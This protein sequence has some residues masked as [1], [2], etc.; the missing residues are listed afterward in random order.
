MADRVV[1]HF[2]VYFGLARVHDHFGLRE[3]VLRANWRQLS[4][5]LALPETPPAP[6]ADL[7]QVDRGALTRL[8]HFC[9]VIGL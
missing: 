7:L 8:E 1:A 4:D 9:A 5:S 3:P 2:G 6:H